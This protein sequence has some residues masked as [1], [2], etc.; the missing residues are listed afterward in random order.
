M[1]HLSEI[2]LYHHVFTE[3]MDKELT[4]IMSDA[5]TKHDDLTKRVLYNLYN[6]CSEL[7]V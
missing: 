1:D 5:L 3:V 6:L 4:V 2:K 7:H